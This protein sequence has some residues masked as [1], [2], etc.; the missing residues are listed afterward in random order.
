RFPPDF[1]G[2]SATDARI[3]Q[4]NAGLAA[5][6]NPWINLYGE[7]L[8]SDVFTF[9]DFKQGSLQT[10]Q[11]YATF[12]DLN[13]SS[14]YAFIGKKNVP[15]GD[16]STLSPFSQSV[17]WHYFGALHEGLGVGYSGEHMHVVAMG[18]NGG[19]GI[20]VADSESRGQLNNFAVNATFL[21]GGEHVAWRLGG[22]FLRGTIYDATIAEHTNPNAFGPYNSA[23]DVN[24]QLN[25]GRLIVA[26][27]FVSTVDDWPA[28]EALVS[29]YRAETAF[30][31]YFF[32][33]PTRYSVSW[34][35]GIQGPSGSEFEFNQQ[36]VLGMGI[37]M[38]PHALLS[39]EYVRSSGF[40]PLLDITTVSDRGVVQDS[41]VMGIT[42]VL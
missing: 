23:W 12:G 10:R 8:F 34:S 29:A 32:S 9:P 1:R 24:A 38:G 4:A 40:A 26:G 28:T 16:M 37:D 19:R 17:V 3:V 31:G 21:G 13:Q 22:G 18:I 25:I 20:R 14:W 33:R 39:F 2:R 11:A 42:V 41:L 35:E 30:D 36:L 7:L 15:F 5:H 6:V 27:E